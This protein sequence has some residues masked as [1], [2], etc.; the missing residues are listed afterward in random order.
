MLGL[1]QRVE[2]RELGITCGFADRCAPFGGIAY[3]DYRGKLYHGELHDE[4]YATYDG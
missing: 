2:A 1:T 4:P 3:I